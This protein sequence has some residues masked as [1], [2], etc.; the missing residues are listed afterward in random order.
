MTHDS[1]GR[2]KV[3]DRFRQV[4]FT[5]RE[6]FKI[7]YKI[8]PKHFF[9]IIF[10]SVVSGF[11]PIFGF[12]IDKLIIDKLV[13]SIGS[14]DLKSVIYSI[15]F[16][17]FFS[18][19]ISLLS[20]FLSGA[21]GILSRNLTR[22]VDAKIDM[23]I[24]LKMSRL[25]LFIIESPDFR[26]RFDR[27]YR[28]S[29]RRIWSLVM[30]VSGIPGYLVEFVV[31][32]GVLILIHPL[33]SLGLI[34]V[35]LPRFFVNLKFIKKEYEL[36][37]RLALP[38]RIWGWIRYFLLRNR[39]YMELK[40]LNI[41]KYLQDKMNATIE[42]VLSKQYSLQKERE[43]NS[44]LGSFPFALYEFVITLFL[45]FKVVGGK[46]TIGSFQLYIRSLGR[47]GRNLDF[48]A[49]SFLEIY[50][51]YIYVADLLW[52]LNLEEEV[53]REERIRVGSNFK[54]EAEDVWFRY[55]EDQ[56]WVLKGINFE[57]SNGEKIAIVG[58][59]G[60]GKSTL[61]KLIGGFY[62]PQKGKIKVGGIDLGELDLQD[63]RSK[64]SILFQ[65]FELYPFSA[66]E[67][68]GFGDVKNIDDLEGIKEAARKAKISDF[69]EK[70]PRQ[71]K[72]P[73]T[74]EFEDGVSP[75]LGQYQRLGISR[76]LFRKEARVIILDEPTSNVDPES[77]EEIFRE[78]VKIAKDRI[79]LFIT[80]RFS[81]VRIADRIFV[82]DDGK[83]IE[84]G[85]HN[86]LMKLNGEYAKLYNLQSQA[87]RH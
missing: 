49:S 50:E 35:S 6:V 14:S 39:N 51:G 16:L 19:F 3:F 83:I 7:I 41:A 9:G 73:L 63:W 24:G 34:L 1:L 69:I 85:T 80:Q 4:A 78:L 66:Q 44:F 62:S 22:R 2:L 32:V 53:N 74:V 52:F 12:Y 56:D 36:H 86:Q 17:A 59:N 79:L 31:A 18:A 30:S 28:E 67:A 43:I 25:P 64:L 40:I 47:A 11:L 42:E 76:V 61:L 57:I 77:E 46:I 45:A 84:Q 27:V 65:E 81:T 60:A 37:I 26:D 5:L 75:S 68:I 70:L 72:N 54:I 10:L 71:Y 48:L 87:Y 38:N 29:T 20:S 13:F 82:V 21:V 23:E 55:K 58:K 8:S 15:S 33:V